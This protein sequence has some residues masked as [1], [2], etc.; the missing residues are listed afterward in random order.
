MRVFKY[1]GLFSLTYNSIPEVS[2]VIIEARVE[3]IA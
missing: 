3:S 1:L 2:S